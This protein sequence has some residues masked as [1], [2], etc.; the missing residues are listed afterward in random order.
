MVGSA[1]RR[2]L[3]AGWRDRPLNTGNA[4]YWNVLNAS[5]EWVSWSGGPLGALFPELSTYRREVVTVDKERLTL[6][7]GEVAGKA[8]S[9][10]NRLLKCRKRC[11][12]A[13]MNW[14]LCLPAR[15]P[16]SRGRRR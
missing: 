10:R 15:S 7:S 12:S 13:P 8:T 11:T 9:C 6:K 14:R 4:R 3:K 1:C 16:A 5:L 2:P